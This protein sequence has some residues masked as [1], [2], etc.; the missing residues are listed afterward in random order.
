MTD[1]GC[2]R[3]KLVFKKKHNEDEE[4][5]GQYL[6][7]LTNLNKHNPCSQVQLVKSL[8]PEKWRLLKHFTVEK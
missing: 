1:N 2:L 3:Q 5:I 4:Y 6:F 7:F 8:K